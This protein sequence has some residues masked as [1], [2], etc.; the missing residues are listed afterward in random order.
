M[1]MLRASEAFPLALSVH[2]QD[3]PARLSL[4]VVASQQRQLLFH[5]EGDCSFMARLQF[6]KSLLPS[7]GIRV[8]KMP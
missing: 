8:L 4:G 5:L 2:R 3:E 7:Y 6:G 1:F